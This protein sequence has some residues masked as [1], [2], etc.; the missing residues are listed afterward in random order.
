LWNLRDAQAAR[1][2]PLEEFDLATDI[3]EIAGLDYDRRGGYQLRTAPAQEL[4]GFIVQRVAAA[5]ERNQEAR[6][7]DEPCHENVP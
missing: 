2:D 4:R 7:N 5:V 1:R 3:Q 6:I